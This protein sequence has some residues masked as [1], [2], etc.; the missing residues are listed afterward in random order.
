VE[1][2][3]E[4]KSNVAN[5]TE[6]VLDMIKLDRIVAVTEL[7]CHFIFRLLS[8]CQLLRAIY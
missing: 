4:I 6:L 7:Y 1:Q 3:F 8:Y 5:I 2:F